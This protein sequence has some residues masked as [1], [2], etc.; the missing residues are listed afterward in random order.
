AFGIAK[1]FGF[2]EFLKDKVLSMAVGQE[3]IIQTFFTFASDYLEKTKGGLL[4]VIGVL[5][6]GYYIIKLMGLME[7]SFNKI[8]GVIEDRPLMRKFT[9]YIALLITAAILLIF[10][11]S[12]NIFITAFLER[13]ISWLSIPDILKGFIDLGFKLIPLFPIWILFI[14][15]YIFLPNKRIDI[16]AATAGGI[17]AGTIFQITQVA[18]LKMQIGVANANAIYGSFAILFLFSVWLQISWSIFLFGAEIAYSWENADAL[19][20]QDLDYRSVSIRMRKLIILRLVL[21]C[22]KRFAN[23]QSPPTNSDIAAQMKIPLRIV[24]L[25]LE[26][27][28]ARNILL[29]VN[30]KDEA[31]GYVPAHDIECLSLMDVI[32]AYEEN[33]EKQIQVGGT[34][35][36]EALEASIDAFSQAAVE[37]KENRNF[38]DI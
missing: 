24:K 32:K 13:F 8:W 25:L 14:F 4:A 31:L 26:K 10:S 22:V 23:K 35:E 33:G 19:E 38:K 28:I 9:D 18:Y 30:L 20:T 27:L 15:F 1:G 21:L 5:I 7:N 3:E 29:E 6:L 17:I 2:H 37:S 16:K 36:F 11:S 12:G 34:M